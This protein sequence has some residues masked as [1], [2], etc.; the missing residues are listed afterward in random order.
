MRK[1]Y[2]KHR[3]VIPFHAYTYFKK[4]PPNSNHPLLPVGT[5]ACSCVRK[6]EERNGGLCR[7]SGQKVSMQFPLVRVDHKIGY[8]GLGPTC[9]SV[10]KSNS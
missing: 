9:L 2:G 5:I 1:E 3:R 7:S 10:A 8:G 4:T 6:K